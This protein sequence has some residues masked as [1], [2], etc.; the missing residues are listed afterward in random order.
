M[1]SNTPKWIQYVYE[2]RFTAHMVSGFE[3]REIKTWYEGASVDWVENDK[4]SKSGLG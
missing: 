2:N 4:E 1:R 3:L